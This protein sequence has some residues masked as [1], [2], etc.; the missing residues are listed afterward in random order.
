MFAITR[1]SHEYAP[2]HQTTSLDRTLGVARGDQV[3][4]NI[5]W[6][7][8]IEAENRE[9]GVDQRVLQSDDR[10]IDAGYRPRKLG[11]RRLCNDSDRNLTCEAAGG[12][13]IV[14]TLMIWPP[15]I[16]DH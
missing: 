14:A 10:F 15:G 12:C 16:L 1:A 6:M 3:T 11:R 8:R 4:P 9:I 7:R 13:M 2:C 5:P